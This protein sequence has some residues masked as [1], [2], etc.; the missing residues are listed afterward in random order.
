MSS[1]D[2]STEAVERMAHWIEE[3]PFGCQIARA[4]RA[5]AAERDALVLRLDAETQ[6]ANELKAD[7]DRLAAERDDALAAL[8]AYRMENGCTRGQ[9]TTQW[10]GEASRLAA[11]RDALREALRKVRDIGLGPDRGSAQWQVS[12]AQEIARAALAQKESPIMT[13]PNGW[14]DPEHPGVPENPERDGW[15]WGVY[16]GV[17]P[18]PFWWDADKQRWADTNGM[19]GLNARRMRYLGPC[20]TP[21][22]VA[23]LAAENARMREAL[24][25]IRGDGDPYGPAG[26]DLRGCIEIARA[27]LA[28]K[29]PNND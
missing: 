25:K 18:E 16:L 20:L 8:A 22:E 11:E 24:A 3:H 10:C 5:L 13:D 28:Q 1:E 15:H 27:A 23:A 7:R 2:T 9:R 26:P 29:E 6:I 17:A 12:C 4:L 19:S 21:A 14:P